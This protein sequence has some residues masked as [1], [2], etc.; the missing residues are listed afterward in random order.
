M[1]LRSYLLAKT[2]LKQATNYILGNNFWRY[3]SYTLSMKSQVFFKKKKCSKIK[4]LEF[5]NFA[6]NWWELG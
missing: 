6:S 3:L 2:V 1:R 4:C 5:G